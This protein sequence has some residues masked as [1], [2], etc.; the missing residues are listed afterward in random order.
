MTD[1]LNNPILDQPNISPN[2]PYYRTKSAKLKSIAT[3][4]DTILLS[5]PSSP[6]LPDP[7][8]N[9]IT[10][11]QSGH[12]IEIDDTPG[13][14]RISVGHKDGSFFE[15]SKNGKVSKIFGKDFEIVLDDKNVIISGNRNITVQGNATFLVA[16]N[17]LTK[18]QGDYETRVEGNMKTYVKGTMD[19]IVEKDISVETFQNLTTKSKLNM[20]T[21]SAGT[22]DLIAQKSLQMETFQNLTIK[23]TGNTFLSSQGTYGIF[24]QQ[25]LQIETLQV[26]STKS[27]SITN[28]YAASTFFVDGSTVQWNLPGPSP[29]S[30]ATPI[31]HIKPISKNFKFGLGFSK[32]LIEPSALEQFLAKSPSPSVLSLADVS[33]TYPKSRKPI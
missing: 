1:I 5:E 32:S 6:T 2:S 25:S 16:G 14:E 11:T 19:T 13:A 9:K 22:Y 24:S 30:L 28:L 27:G 12:V 8:Y 31:S 23:S 26:L 20:M 17:C 7:Q 15:L 21:Y 29:S 10:V 3:A 4:D 33:V 18:V